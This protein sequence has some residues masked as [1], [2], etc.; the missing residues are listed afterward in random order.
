MAAI[1]MEVLPSAT[2]FQIIIEKPFLTVFTN[3]S[4]DRIN[5]W[6]RLLSKDQ[7]RRHS[8]RGLQTAL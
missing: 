7:A 5:T 8:C 1:F 6:Y 3:W 4:H 2:V